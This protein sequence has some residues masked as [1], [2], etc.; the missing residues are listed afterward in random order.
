MDFNGEYD[1]RELKANKVAIV[2]END[3]GLHKT[4]YMKAEAYFDDEGL[5]K[6]RDVEMLKIKVSKNSETHIRVTDEERARFPREYE[7]FKRGQQIQVTGTPIDQWPALMP[8]HVA[9]LRSLEI[10]SVE[11]L[12]LTPD[13]KVALI[14]SD[15]HGLKAKAKA[16]VNAAKDQG[17]VMKL[18]KESTELKETVSAQSEQIEE[19]K[20]TIADLSK[21]KAKGKE[22]AEVTA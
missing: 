5:T 21:K 20:K 18:A 1:Q 16:Y 14:G 8:S 15:G 17:A 3:A 6:F 4:F 2:R 13:Q 11:Q 7:M 9:I 12:A 10:Y 22:S 19:L